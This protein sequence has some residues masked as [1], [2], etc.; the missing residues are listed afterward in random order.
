MRIARKH[1]KKL[2]LFAAATLAL[3]LSG[4]GMLEGNYCVFHCGSAQRASTPL[5]EFLYG[6]E[7]KVPLKDATVTLKLPIRVGLAF[8]PPRDGH[9]ADAP[10]PVQR[11]RI[12]SSIRTNF[13]GLPY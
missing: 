5:V 4:C 12:L 6:D 9:A 13:A 1:Q 2:R 10:T 3:T 8:L 7:Q 11:D